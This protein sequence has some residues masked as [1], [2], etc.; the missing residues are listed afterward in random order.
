M[1]DIEKKYMK[2]MLKILAIAL[3]CSMS[4]NIS[5]HTPADVIAAY[6]QQI[7]DVKTGNTD[8]YWAARDRP[9]AVLNH[10]L[11]NA[12]IRY[13]KQKS[14]LETI[15]LEET[16]PLHTAHN[17]GR[18][19]TPDEFDEVILELTMLYQQKCREWRVATESIALG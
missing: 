10:F 13:T 9:N 15:K 5:A 7:N 4:P 3:A 8:L 19:F 1:I 14:A 6:K 18:V 2:L 16:N 11:K 17:D 12:I